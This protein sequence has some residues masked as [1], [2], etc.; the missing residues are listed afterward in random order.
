MSPSSSSSST[1]INTEQI[2]NW[3]FKADYVET[4]NCYL[5]IVIGLGLMPIRRQQEAL[6]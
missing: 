1:T 6:A 5:A 3:N 4:C 2:P